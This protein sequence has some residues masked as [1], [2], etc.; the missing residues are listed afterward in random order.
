M[1]AHRRP[2]APNP[3]KPR[4]RPVAPGLLSRGAMRMRFLVMVMLVAVPA[5]AHADGYFF[6]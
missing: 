1:N 4:S 6:N 2:S 3:A 5:A